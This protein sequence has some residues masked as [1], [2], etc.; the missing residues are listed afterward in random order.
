[1]G[2]RCGIGCCNCDIVGRE[3]QTPALRVRWEL[4]N[5]QYCHQRVGSISANI[6]EGSLIK[7]F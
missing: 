2:G 6:R 3:I 7:S 1:M 4:E 5:R